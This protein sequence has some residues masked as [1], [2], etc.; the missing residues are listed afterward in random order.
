MKK[1]K[2]ISTKEIENFLLDEEVR[3]CMDWGKERNPFTLIEPGEVQHSRI[4]AWLL[5]PR[6]GHLQ[7]DYFIKALI[8][9]ALETYKDAENISVL[10]KNAFFKEWNVFDIEQTSFANAVVWPEFQISE[11]QAG[12]RVDITMFDGANELSIFIENKFGSLEGEDQTLE[13]F[14]KLEE[15]LKS[16][17][18][19]RLYIFLDYNENKAKSKDWISLN[20]DW[21]QNALKQLIDRDAIPASVEYVLKG[22]YEYLSDDRSS[23]PYH[24]GP[25]KH[26]AAIARKHQNLLKFMRKHKNELAKQTTE[27]LL[28]DEPKKIEDKLYLL[29]WQHPSFFW[30]LFDYTGWEYI[31][32]RLE[33]TIGNKYFEYD[34]GK[35]WFCIHK[36]S[37]SRYYKKD[38]DEWGIQLSVDQE[39]S[40][41]N[42]LYLIF[43]RDEFKEEY[44]KKLESFAKA[45]GG[46]MKLK[47]C[48]TIIKKKIVAND[49]AI[50]KE[51]AS[52]YKK[53]VKNIGS[54][55]NK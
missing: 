13:Y 5:N 21:L 11:S 30:G 33:R 31:G 28:L 3:L 47:N 26:L 2:K 53:M 24:S 19:Y 40:G 55:D 46:K 9:T 34:S 52:M 12:K 27:R 36:K 25:E 23:N 37:W 20:Y 29:Y 6:E 39:P 50:V 49:D 32:E 22:Y 35:R 48:V 54:L 41:I 45:M 38:N 51:L 14:K 7:G 8:R 10:E 1:A 43:K 44:A 15:L 4:L 17:D 18:P 16:R 42:Y